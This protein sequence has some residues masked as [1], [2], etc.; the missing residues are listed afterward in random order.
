MSQLGLT[1][2]QAEDFLSSLSPFGEGNAIRLALADPAGDEAFKKVVLET[3]EL[4]G[5]SQTWDNNIGVKPHTGGD[6]IPEQGRIDTGGNQIPERGPIDTG[7]N[8]IPEQ[9][10]TDTGGDQ[11]PERIDNT[12]I[13]PLPDNTTLDDIALLSEKS[14]VPKP[15]ISGKEGSKEVP[16][17]AKG[18]RPKVGE[19]GNK[20]AERLLDNKY[21]KGNY[22]KGPNT[23]FNKIR[24]WGDRAFVDP[25]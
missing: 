4:Y 1:Q 24:K 13:T 14:K 19:N 3:Y 17:W 21:G 6:Q 12:H 2:T 7:G 5:T 16:S 9:G 18:E 11:I 8:Q 15:G 20:F 22:D 10:R 25:K 23:E